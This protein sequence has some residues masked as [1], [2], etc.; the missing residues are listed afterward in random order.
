[1]ELTSIENCYEHL[2]HVPITLPPPKYPTV[3]EVKPK[4]KQHK[5]VVS[6]YQHPNWANRA[7][8]VNQ[9][10]VES[11]D[12]DS[13]SENTQQVWPHHGLDA[14]Y[15]LDPGGRLGVYPGLLQEQLSSNEEPDDD[16]DPL[17]ED[18]HLEPIELTILLL[19]LSKNLCYREGIGGPQGMAVSLALLPHLSHFLLALQTD[20]GQGNIPEGWNTNTV[21]FLEHYTVRVILTVASFASLQ[22]NG[23]SSLAASGAV[24]SLLEVAKQNLRT[25]SE[26][27]LPESITI[28]SPLLIATDILHGI[29]LLLH[30]IFYCI[31]LNPTFLNSSLK[32]LSEVVDNQGLRLSQTALLTWEKH[33]LKQNETHNEALLSKIHMVSLVESVGRV[34][35]SLKRAKIN[36]IHTMRCMKKRHKTCDFKH[37]MHHHHDVLGIASSAMTDSQVRYSRYSLLMPKCCRLKIHNFITAR[38]RSCGKVMFYRC[39]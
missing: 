13:E 10:V 34:I 5:L 3:A 23:I 16:T 8:H 24:I 18:V 17:G 22:P 1:M 28:S 12:S 19:N 9:P 15:P 4:L 20:H 31:P 36:Y 25:A 21:S 30:T 27:G 35:T 39:L 29:W 33:H 37:Y 6:S 38:K 11:S 26:K 32:L 7:Q 14:L 2:N